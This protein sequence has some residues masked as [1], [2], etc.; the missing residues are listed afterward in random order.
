LLEEEAAAERAAM[1]T[2]VRKKK[3]RKDKKGKKDKTK[4]VAVV[5]V[6]HTPQEQGPTSHSKDYMEAPSQVGALSVGRVRE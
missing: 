5:A 2:E 1:A 4:G 3:G 6:T